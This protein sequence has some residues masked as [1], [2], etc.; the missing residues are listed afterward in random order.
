M[1]LSQPCVQTIANLTEGERAYLLLEVIDVSFCT[2]NLNQFSYGHCHLQY[3]FPLITFQALGETAPTA[4]LT[5][6][7]VYLDF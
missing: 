2:F 4:T 1:C 5:L 3:L 7:R 6:W